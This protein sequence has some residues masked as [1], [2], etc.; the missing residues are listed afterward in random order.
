MAHV[1]E[2]SAPLAASLTWNEYRAHPKAS[3]KHPEEEKAQVD[4]QLTRLA[5]DGSVC[6]VLLH[7]NIFHIK[8]NWEEK[9]FICSFKSKQFSLNK[10]SNAFIFSD[11]N[12]WFFSAEYLD[13]KSA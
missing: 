8:K 12:F 9:A 2:E 3:R 11:K 1:Q 6:R 5:V 13:H 7:G 10:T 4:Q